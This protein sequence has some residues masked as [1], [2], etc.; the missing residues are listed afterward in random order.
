MIKVS[1]FNLF[2]MALL[3]GAATFTSCNSDELIV[4]EGTT[5]VVDPISLTGE[6]VKTQF[7]I[8]IPSAGS[9]K[10]LAQ[11]TVQAEKDGSVTFRGLKNIFMVPF[12]LDNTT[13]EGSDSQVNVEGTSLLT[14]APVGKIDLSDFTTF[15][16]EK[17][18]NAKYYMDVTIPVNTTNMLFYAEGGSSSES[19]SANPADVTYG[20]LKVNCSSDSWTIE[21]K[22]EDNISFELKPIYTATSTESAETTILA[23]LNAILKA[24]GF[25][26]TGTQTTADDEGNSNEETNSGQ[27]ITQLFS[28]FT[29][30]KSGSAENVLYTVNE[31]YR[32]AN[33][34]KSTSNEKNTYDHIIT[35]ITG[36]GSE[37]SSSTSPL[38][39]TDT[40]GSLKY[41][42][43]FSENAK[44][45]TNKNL[46]AGVAQLKYDNEKNEFA[47]VHTA[48]STSVVI[49][50]MSAADFGDYTYPASL[51]YYV[52]SPIK[53]SSS[54]T[55]QVTASQKWSDYVNGQNNIFDQDKVMSNSQL[56]ILKDQVQYAV[57]RFDVIP[58]FAATTIF[59]KDMNTR[60][61]LQDK[62]FTVK[63]L[64][65]GGQKNV[66][67]Q[68]KPQSATDAKE[69]T[70]YD[71]TF[72]TVE[73]G[74]TASSTDVYSTLVLETAKRGSGEQTSVNFAI[75]LI[76]NT[77][78][79]FY[80]V[81]GIVPDGGTFYLVGKL[82]TSSSDTTNESVFAQ[83]KI[84]T[85][86]VTIKS[87]ANAYNVVPDLRATKLSFG[88]SVDLTWQKGLQ[89]DVTIE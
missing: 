8:N 22:V 77:G 5:Q 47:Y 10:R 17:T 6:A 58:K 35:A 24:D 32:I 34:R 88:L 56:V 27:T 21:S 63:G 55:T 61:D 40:D 15:T 68:F 41:V 33:E 20:G 71:Q 23:A 84:T 38:F 75:E 19:T 83:D 28:N 64:L 72:D 51:Y 12:A 85:A 67:W 18:P 79:A 37:N 2:S 82:E 31:L 26:S 59:D 48:E 1:K 87:L 45:P 46:P 73:K 39:T 44:Y 53:A 81:D 36:S 49:G 69:Y 86:N 60:I 13:T 50:T 74:V 62:M 7:S 65:V 89:A 3:A 42:D 52:N 25:N 11:S 14:P 57:A 9:S 66:D 78:D 80:G 70:I 29:Q 43:S 54:A 4:E 76:N 16:V 30:L